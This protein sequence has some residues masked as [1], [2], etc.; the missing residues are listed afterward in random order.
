M[1]D[2]LLVFIVGP[3]ASGKTAAAVKLAKA[4]DSEVISADS[5]QFYREMVVGTAVPTE[6]EMDGVPHHLIGNLSVHDPYNVSRYEQDVLAL[7]DVLFKKHQVV[8]V[9]GGSGMY[10]DVIE[11]GIDLLPDIPTEIR[12]RV[13]TEYQEKG[14]EWLQQ[15]VL[16]L[17]PDYFHQA[18]VRNPVRLMRAVEIYRT[19]GRKFSSMRSGHK[20]KRPFQML[21]LG[22]RHDREVLN[23]RIHDRTDSM[24][25]QDWIGE[26]RRLMPFR[27]LPALRTV[28]YQE[29]FAYLCDEMS[30]EETVEKIKTE[31][32]RYAKRQMTWFQRDKEIHWFNGGEEEAMLKLIQ[33][34]AAR[35]LRDNRK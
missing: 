7:L 6:E 26:C 31:T 3:T 14:L 30:L 25:R 2:R 8:L 23:Q 34:H 24:L 5:R 35:L 27:D 17:D 15:E 11:H 18:D 13:A 1:D 28:G 9:A 10:F 21:K 4:L 19:T 16:A 32:R 12:A 22:I 20:Q 33:Q 29:I